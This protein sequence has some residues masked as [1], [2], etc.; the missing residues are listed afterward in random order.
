MGVNLKEAD[1]AKETLMLLTLLLPA[2]LL[3][4]GAAPRQVMLYEFGDNGLTQ[5]LHRG[6]GL[7]RRLARGDRARST[8]RRKTT[9]PP[10][11]KTS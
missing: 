11:R 1:H 10:C 8:L 5:Y 9:C 6:G 2:A 3:L 7:P 4:A